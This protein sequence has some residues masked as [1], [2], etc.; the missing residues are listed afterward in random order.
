MA[1]NRQRSKSSSTADDRF[2]SI[3]TAMDKR[4][5]DWNCEVRVFRRCRRV[6][7]ARCMTRRCQLDLDGDRRTAD[8]EMG[9]RLNGAG[10]PRTAVGGRARNWNDEIMVLWRFGG[11]ENRLKS[12]QSARQRI[13]IRRPVLLMRR[14]KTPDI[15]YRKTYCK[16]F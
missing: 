3:W 6:W 10:S 7:A 11:L 5:T 8:G 14:S 4:A 13:F 1:W 12:A 16:Y 15:G 9:E 2:G